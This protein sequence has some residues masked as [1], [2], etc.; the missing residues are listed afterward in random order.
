MARVLVTYGWCRTSYVIVRSLAKR[1][2]DV[3]A[4]SSLRPAMASWSRFTRGGAVVRDP[5]EEPEAF[6]TDVA[7]LVGRWGIEAIFPGHE[8]A[9]P[10]RQYAGLLP[11][12]VALVCP[13]LDDLVRG[14]D[15][16]STA[17]V[18]VSAGVHVPDT[19]F[20]EHPQDAVAAAELLGFP[21][22]VKLR[23]SNGGKGVV[24][25]ED[26]A[27]VRAA[28]DGP[29]RG[30][31]DRPGHVA[32][33]Q[34]FATGSV[35][36]AC[37]I[38]RDGEPIAMYGE[39][40]L[41]TKDDGF[42][43]STYRCPE[44]SPALLEATARMVRALRWSGIGHFDFLEEAGTGRLLFLEMN[45]RPW[46]AIH[47]AYVNGFD[48]PAAALALALGA[49]DL[50]GFFPRGRDHG[51]RHSV[52]LVGEGIRL[53]HRLMLRGRAWQVHTP[54]GGR[55]HLQWWRARLDG[56]EWHDPLAFAAE[57]TC[58]LSEFVR[59]RGHVN[60]HT[61]GMHAPIDLAERP[62]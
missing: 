19:L 17:R 38:A 30:L 15:K 58:Y 3:Y 40:Y 52:W 14:V 34:R 22:V 26:A 61:D 18:A 44:P 4:C 27:A 13:P 41:R 60:P 47:L 20:P 57:C 8:D 43:T 45:P 59:T 11:D 46:G 32:L 50:E 39:R 10:L 21:V 29:F 35:V 49:T 54:A 51:L 16:A 37:L 42:G 12:D 48:F 9:I 56:F 36:G 7:A 24:V 55:P 5:F 31:G 23:H 1:G 28:F 33:V 2:H 62:R 53:V 6:V 25:A